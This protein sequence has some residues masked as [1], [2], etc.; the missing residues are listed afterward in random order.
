M[1][2]AL[3]QMKVG[4]SRSGNIIH[5]AELL[6]EA[7][8]NGAELAILPEIFTSMYIQQQFK[9]N[10]EAVPGGDAHLMLK[11]KAKTRGIYIIGG[12]VVMKQDEDY[13][14]A[15]MVL[16]KKG[17]LM[18]IHKKIHLFDVDLP[19]IKFSESVVFTKGGDLTIV[20]IGEFCVGIAVCYDIRF[21]EYIRLLALQGAGL[22]VC[23]AAFSTTTG[24]AHW[25]LLMRSRAVDNQVYL[26]GCSPAPY[27]TSLYPY[28]GHSM[29]VDPWGEI[30]CE[31]GEYE[32]II[33]SDI[34]PERI[35]QVRKNMDLHKHRRT[36]LYNLKWNG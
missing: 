1:K 8:D 26:A 13:Y 32:E 19:Q 9:R 22:I 6:D 21:P 5:A 3:C 7:A 24:S 33:Y 20:M 29:V 31:G 12:S 2:L 16:D 18:A 23:P 28:Y 11:Q 4:I 10:S 15:C 30:I 27:K 14:N 25:E 17:E 34:S 36:D 35:N